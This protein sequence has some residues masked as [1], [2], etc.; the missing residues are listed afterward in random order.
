MFIKQRQL[1]RADSLGF[2][3]S[4]G[5]VPKFDESHRPEID[6]MHL[7]SVPPWV[8]NFEQ[9]LTAHGDFAEQALSNSGVKSVRTKADLIRDG[10]M[11]ILFGMQ[12]APEHMTIKRLRALTKY[13]L[14]VMS[15]AY[16][17]PTAYGDGFKGSR[18]LTRAGEEL[19]VWMAECG[20]ILDLSHAGHATAKGALKFI[21]QENLPM[22]PM[23]SHS[24]C[25]SVFP[26]KRNLPSDV[27]NGIA[28]LDGYVGIPLVT[29][30]LGK[31]GGD[32]FDEFAR[33]VAMATNIMGTKKVGIGSDCTYVDM[34]IEQAK[35]QYDAMTKKMQTRGSFGEYFPDRP[36][37][38]I[39]RGSQLFEVLKGYLNLDPGV[40]G[41]NFQEYLH[42]SLPRE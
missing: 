6:L 5:T 15:L 40:C 10:S 38:L 41:R 35:E 9:V 28:E 39:E 7:T 14:R 26:H 22:M 19:I 12:N 37:S 8:K 4:P 27:L 34:T 32:Y 36:E 11:G 30:L 31:E 3:T 29:F 25:Y 42:R 21:R 2:L 24:G 18:K 1:Y 13:G 16:D 23:A 17:E 33:H 20:I